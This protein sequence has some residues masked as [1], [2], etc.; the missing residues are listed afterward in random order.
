MAVT[1]PLD[2]RLLAALAEVGKVAVHELAARVGMDPRE[3]AYRLVALSG[4]GLPLLVGVES[5]PRGI[6]AAL[7]GTGYR[8]PIPPATPPATPRTQP[9]TAPGTVGGPT[10]TTGV[11]D[12]AISTWGPPQTSAWAR[13]DRPP[14]AR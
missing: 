5:D 8:T 1:D 11:V 14:T 6:H 4:S 7:M 13:G 3:A 12:P 9:P 10:T 2:A